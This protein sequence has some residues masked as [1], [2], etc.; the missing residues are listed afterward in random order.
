MGA[1]LQVDINRIRSVNQFGVAQAAQQPFQ[2]DT[3]GRAEAALQHEQALAKAREIQKINAD[4]LDSSLKGLNERLAES[5]QIQERLKALGLFE[6]SKHGPIFGNILSE[7]DAAEKKIQDLR[8][9]NQKAFNDWVDDTNRV[10]N[11]NEAVVKSVTNLNEALTAESVS[12]IAIGRALGDV[13]ARTSLM[14]SATAQTS[15]NF[16][17]LKALFT[18]FVAGGDSLQSKL[19][20]VRVAIKDLFSQGL[21]F[22][23]R[24]FEGGVEVTD[25][26]RRSIL[27][28]SEEDK[29]SGV[30]TQLRT[31]LE[32]LNKIPG[33]AESKFGQQ[34]KGLTTFASDVE[35]YANSI[36]KLKDVNKDYEDSVNELRQKVSA[37]SAAQAKLK[38]A[39]DKVAKAAA[40]S[41]AKTDAIAERNTLV[42]AAIGLAKDYERTL[43]TVTKRELELQGTLE[44]LTPLQNQFGNS[45]ALSVYNNRLV[46]LQQNAAGI[47]TSFKDLSAISNVAFQSILKRENAATGVKTLEN[48]VRAD[49]QKLRIALAD[50]V[51]STENELNKLTVGGLIT[52]ETRNKIR[53]ALQSLTGV[54][55][56]GGDKEA[57][58]TAFDALKISIQEGFNS[59]ATGN[60][61][62]GAKG[63]VSVLKFIENALESLRV[64]AAR[65][66]ERIHAAFAGN[67]DESSAKT[68]LQR[69]TAVTAAVNEA[70]SAGIN[71]SKSF[72]TKV[73]QEQFAALTTKAQD[74]ILVIKNL[75]EKRST[76]LFN[77]S[78]FIEYE[79]QIKNTI[80][81]L[82]NLINSENTVG[83]KNP[84]RDLLNQLTVQR[85]EFN[86]KFGTNVVNG[87]QD[88]IDTF[89]AKFREIVPVAG[90]TATEA[91][92]LF[93][94]SLNRELQGITLSGISKVSTDIRKA[95][96]AAGTDNI[97]V[98][99]LKNLQKEWDDYARKVVDSYQIIK[100]AQRSGAQFNDPNSGISTTLTTTKTAIENLI[101]QEQ[102]IKKDIVKWM[103]DPDRTLVGGTQLRERVDALRSAYKLLGTD[104]GNISSEAKSA[105]ASLKELGRV[106]PN[107]NV[108]PLKATLQGAVDSAKDLA[109]QKEYLDQRIGG[110]FESDLK[111]ITANLVKGGN[112]LAVFQQVSQDFKNADYF[113]KSA[114]DLQQ[115]YNTI[116]KTRT[117]LSSAK[118]GLE[119][120]RVGIDP[121]IRQELDKQIV[122]IDEAINSLTAYN[123]VLGQ[124]KSSATVAPFERLQTVFNEITKGNIPS[125]KIFGDFENQFRTFQVQITEATNLSSSL[126]K[127]LIDTFNSSKKGIL[128]NID[129]LK[130]WLRVLESMQAAGQ[131]RFT[132]PLTGTSTSISTLIYNVEQLI[133]KFNGLESS[134]INASTILKDRLNTTLGQLQLKAEEAGIKFVELQARLNAVSSAGAFTGTYDKLRDLLDLL[135]KPI[136]Q[137]T[138]F[139][140]PKESYSQITQELKAYRQE[141]VATVTWMDRYVQAAS[142]DS[143]INKTK[144]YQDQVAQLER[145]RNLLLEVDQAQQRL[146]AHAS[147]ASEFSALKGSLGGVSTN[148]HEL[149]EEGAL[150]S[151]GM[152]K[153][154]EF[155][156]KTLPTPKMDLSGVDT[157]ITGVI[158]RLG[159][160][161][162]EANN[163]RK[164][165]H[166]AFNQKF[167]SGATLESVSRYQQAFAELEKQLVR[168]RSGMIQW[169][170]G[171]QM[172]G[173]AMEEP[174]KKAVQGFIDFSDRMGIV[175]AVS[176]A[177]TEQ[178]NQL[179]EAAM[180]MGATTRFFSEQAAEG[181]EK[182]ARAG[183][184]VQQQLEVLPSTMRLAQAAATDLATAAEIT[185]T[186]MNEFRMDPAQFSEAADVIAL[187]ANATN[188]SVQD[189]GYSFKYV[190]ALAANIGADFS[191]LAA[192]IALMHNAGLKG[193]MSGTAL[194]GILQALF[195]PTKDEAKLMEDLSQRIGGLGLT[196]S[197][198]NGKFV[199]FSSILKQLESAGITTGEVLRLFGQRAGPGMAALLAMGSD[200]VKALEEDLKNAAGTSAKMADVMENTLKGRVLLMQSAFKALSEQVG[201]NLE[202]ALKFLS[203]TLAD[204]TNKFVALR[205]EFPSLSAVADN[206]LGL[207]AVLAATLGGMAVTFSMIIVPT[208]QFIGFLKTLA[209]TTLVAAGA[210]SVQTQT[211]KSAAL[212]QEIFNKVLIET[213]G[214]KAANG[215]VTA[216]ETQLIIKRTAAL[217]ADTA[218][219]VVNGGAIAASTGKMAGFLNILK[220]IVS[221]KGLGAVAKFL[222]MNPYGLLI[223]AATTIGILTLTHKKSVEQTNV[224]LQKQNEIIEYG[225]K[226]I[227]IL[228]NKIVN[229]SDELTRLVAKQKELQTGDKEGAFK[230]DVAIDADKAKLQA[231]LKELFIRL[232]DE[233]SK[234]KGSFIPDVKFDSQG[235]FSKFRF[236]VVKTGEVIDV[237][238]NGL[239][240]AGGPLRRLVAVTNEE[241]IAL[242][243]ATDDAARFNVA[244][245]KLGKSTILPSLKFTTEGLKKGSGFDISSLL[246]DI[247]GGEDI[248]A[249]NKK[250]NAAKS[251]LEQINVLRVKLQ[252]AVASGDE[253]SVRQ[254][255][256][257]LRD[258]GLVSYQLSNTDEIINVL[259]D[260]EVVFATELGNLQQSVS[261]N[262]Q[263]YA[264][265]L[266]KN[267]NQITG[268]T[269]AQILALGEGEF[270]GFIATL[271][272]KELTGRIPESE[273]NQAVRN[274]T[275]I[276]IKAIT[277]NISGTKV[278]GDALKDPF[279]AF[280][281]N[282][283]SVESLLEQSS[284]DLK[285]KLDEQKKLLDRFKSV[286]DEVKKYQDAVAEQIKTRFE[287]K[288][289]KIDFEL[290]VD[291]TKVEQQYDAAIKDLERESKVVQFSIPFEL[292]AGTFDPTKFESIK[293]VHTTLL[294]YEDEFS[295]AYVDAQVKRVTDSLAV[296]RDALAQRKD[297]LDA[298]LKE[299]ATLYGE[300][301]D[302]FLSV[303][304]VKTLD[305]LKELQARGQEYQKYLKSEYDLTKNS[306]KEL[307]GLQEQL[308]NNQKKLVDEQT[309]F[310][311]TSLKFAKDVGLLGA[312]EAEKWDLA[313]E[314][315]KAF[316]AQAEEAIKVGD[317][318]K[319][320]D[321]SQKS[322]AVLQSLLS[323]L[324][325]ESVTKKSVD[326][327]LTNLNLALEQAD[328]ESTLA[329][330]TARFDNLQLPDIALAPKFEIKPTSFATDDTIKALQTF[331]SVVGS[332]FKDLKLLTGGFGEGFQYGLNRVD[333]NIRATGSGII[334]VLRNTKSQVAASDQSFKEFFKYDR[335]E[336]GIDVWTD[337]SKAMGVMIDQMHQADASIRSGFVPTIQAVKTELGNV[338]YGFYDLNGAMTKMDLVSGTV[339]KPLTTQLLESKRELTGFRSLVKTE[340]D[341][342]TRQSKVVELPISFK[343][344]FS[345]L[346]GYELQSMTQ[347]STEALSYEVTLNE[348]LFELRK[349]S[350]QQD[351][352]TTI[353]TTEKKKNSVNQFLWGLVSEY[354]K[355][356]KAI[357]E[358]DI[359]S[360]IDYKTRKN[361]AFNFTL[362][363]LQEELTATQAAFDQQFAAYQEL[364]N[365]KKAIQERNIL[366]QAHAAKNLAA[367]DNV[368]RTDSEKAYISRQ[369]I[370]Q[371][372]SDV[373]QAIAKKDYDRAQALVEQRQQL[374]D[375]MIGQLKPEDSYSKWFLRQAQT[376]ASQ[377]FGNISG[378]LT[379]QVEEKSTSLAKVLDSYTERMNSLKDKIKT[380]RV[381]VERLVEELFKLQTL[382]NKEQAAKLLPL[383][384]QAQANFTTANTGLITTN[385]GEIKKVGNEIDTLT[386]NSQNLSTAL[387]AAGNNLEDLANKGLQL[388]SETLAINVDDKQATVDLIAFSIMAQK[389]FNKLNNTVL[390]IDVDQAVKEKLNDYQGLKKIVSDAQDY[391]LALKGI[392][393]RLPAIHAITEETTKIQRNLAVGNQLAGLEATLKS[394]YETVDKN[395]GKELIDVDKE[396][397]QKDLEE[398]KRQLDGLDKELAN[399]N[400]TGDERKALT[401][402]IKLLYDA[403]AQLDSAISG[404]AVDKT[405][406]A[407]LASVINDAIPVIAESGRKIGETAEQGM[408]DALKR[409]IPQSQAILLQLKNLQDKFQIN[410]VE[411]GE[412]AKS[413]SEASRNASQTFAQLGDK[414]RKALD[415]GEIPV[416]DKARPAAEELLRVLNEIKNVTADEQI[417]LED[418]LNKLAALQT[419]LNKANVDLNK[420][421]AVAKKE[422]ATAATQ[423]TV[424]EQ[425]TNDVKRDSLALAVQEKDYLQARLVTLHEYTNLLAGINQNSKDAQGNFIG[426]F[427]IKEDSLNLLNGLNTLLIDYVNKLNDAKS[428]KD[429]AFDFSGMSAS[430]NAVIKRMLMIEDLPQGIKDALL[431]MQDQF[432]KT[433]NLEIKPEIKPED[434]KKTAEDT[435]KQVENVTTGDKAPVVTLLTQP[436]MEAAAALRIYIYN[437]L[438]Q[439]IQI[440][441][442]YVQEGEIPG[443][444]GGKEG[445]LF[446]KMLGGLITVQ[447]FAA[448]G[449]AKFKALTSPVVPGSGSG[450]KIPAMLEPGEFVIRKAA[451]GRLGIDFLNVLNSGLV[452]FKQLGG[453]VYNT[454]INTLNKLSNMIQPSFQLP[455]METANSAPLANVS[456]TIQDKPFNIRMQKDQI[457]SFVEAAKKLKRGLIK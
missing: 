151:K 138:L 248:P 22:D 301:A 23:L 272:R 191:D 11:S 241:S 186:I 379:Q 259:K 6:E 164:S 335:G 148:L 89:K 295:Q 315:V 278:L 311:D 38:E 416:N 441:I 31:V 99:E 124:I 200:K 130:I 383:A 234:L 163:F 452:Q 284:K 412:F 431:A 129:D 103:E 139:A 289:A 123:K 313:V 117:S 47:K 61:E 170:M 251:S 218:A 64:S 316:N 150:L 118:T 333:G 27:A 406:F 132:N 35:A 72:E 111:T 217:A 326:K 271:V 156:G 95:I 220:S 418:K 79:A 356:G 440:P 188:A 110:N 344:D 149:Y 354:T 404:T 143:N 122:K 78:D 15:T 443:P 447:R 365:K 348:R 228:G 182:L 292:N 262:Y 276:V 230:L 256:R 287:V 106:G 362:K 69:T 73:A 334:Q 30:V 80:S 427:G 273:L 419:Q 446:G 341:E 299:L 17:P 242:S 116:E 340:V 330:A 168:F 63:F 414:L 137:T 65:G 161:Q 196:I 13:A 59:L 221:F 367:I 222:T 376:Q 424:V 92:Q 176:N 396:K 74:L 307:M 167:A 448:G 408:I 402:K 254:I 9:V 350:A 300:D 34:V 426:A 322:Q 198:S 225:R 152:A 305:Y 349:Q 112:S 438:A 5:Y 375:T 193:T 291:K 21:R 126:K 119:G 451:V 361:E 201:H 389:E 81:A 275:D 16:G 286:I 283:K 68:L 131:T 46:Q 386:Q 113:G 173:Q 347:Y 26:M 332:E 83:G 324:D 197:D 261:K 44:K 339:F 253:F 147:R 142:K 48:Q 159:L 8:T 67:I 224:E 29:L 125:L 244:V 257:T 57:I 445:G 423:E 208:V 449:M 153:L 454:P 82:K 269:N 246:T 310:N 192:N 52:A 223:S 260:K 169:T 373:E 88:S 84:L 436:A 453:M 25:K 3:S 429:Q 371:N 302:K 54:I 417:P 288:S 12:V 187:A 407:E 210:M 207:V 444:A 312:S 238:N 144:E 249:L 401:D 359:K 179:N 279:N 314:S 420:A 245:E 277:T 101:K 355:N 270:G 135:K 115:L 370:L 403:K 317:L 85:E 374:I 265:L 49:G 154:F 430:I 298:K 308:R 146:Q 360:Q 358:L 185:T 213:L 211:T 385:E 66:S 87:I 380:T 250:I 128:E 415:L 390:K 409:L 321:L 181:L 145:A 366:F 281:N 237:L 439:P 1:A 382:G 388:K 264:D 104:L 320:R 353:N 433:G 413:I 231:Q 45:E 133:T 171:V 457:E 94:K 76:Q 33:A 397:L 194:R 352:E 127:E 226:E 114:Y 235:N 216:E 428:K 100:A 24:G 377:D 309:K 233:S 387:D 71:L 450:D 323:G 102:D 158:N 134:A 70:Q 236:E 98:A 432:N 285:A 363:F 346:G 77:K 240:N 120:R 327:L 40:G 209:V 189:L 263:S 202:P 90:L 140:A 342:L 86:K 372:E 368:D 294:T 398:V 364:E 178:F 19:Y 51:I 157:Q 105:E 205:A 121:A 136:E 183:F 177:T 369:Q 107:A 36:K 39:D 422:V 297:A 166:D 37:L 243:K 392:Q 405:K 62:Q 232:T 456:L 50:L 4:N 212:A 351:L 337:T 266:I 442:Q 214:A 306:I 14:N 41:Q 229:T 303:E 165:I 204:I 160:G 338:V 203:N 331:K 325:N 141:L 18:N 97:L 421:Q 267:I 175:R 378:A 425:K 219:Q 410:P 343:V 108:A 60:V 58:K 75:N 381:E 172:F 345:K 96:S 7:Y 280:A 42:N 55:S 328:F 180:L 293:N 296:E 2:V 239:E 400:L 268:K 434:I 329:K 10:V 391:Q 395:R 399:T 393:D 91:G 394:V 174:F 195:N 304:N 437:V 357:D 411:G 215:V 290:D 255:K 206:L 247:F 184:T 455:Q 20:K 43:T 162:A 227:E 274:V 319:A 32:F 336:L 318:G 93:D 199:G 109:K 28:L 435:K 155:M 384:G 252:E 56:K 282:M 190:G 258:T 53:S